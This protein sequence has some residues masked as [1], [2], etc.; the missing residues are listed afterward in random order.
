MSSNKKFIMSP[1]QA[2]MLTEANARCNIF[3]G[4][5][6]SGKS[7]GGFFLLPKRIKQ[8]KGVEGFCTLCG[9]TE[10]TIVRNTIMPLQEMYGHQY[11]S[12]LN[13]K[14]GECYIFGQRFLALPANDEK[15]ASK[16]QGLTIKYSFNDEAALYPENFHKQLQARLSAPGAMSDNFLN[17][18]SPYH[19][20]K[21]DFIDNPNIQ[22]YR[23]TFTLDD[24]KCFLSPEFIENLKREYSGVYKKRYI[25]GLWAIAEGSIYDMWSDE[26]NIIEELD[27]IPEYYFTSI[28]YATASVCT[29]ILFAVKGNQVRAVKQYYYDAVK[30]GRQKTDDE[31]VRD[32]ADFTNGFDVQYGYIDPSASSLKLELRTKSF[33]YFR[34][35]DND[36]L[37]GIKTVSKFIARGNYKVLSCCKELIREKSSYAWDKKAQKL[38]ID[39]PIKQDDH[40]SDAERYG[41]HSHLRRVA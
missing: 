35:A 5:V 3:D 40:S 17:P 1:K 38:G 9:K 29:F 33:G 26:I 28:D 20:F 16:A 13:Y 27:F 24:G 6:R 19:Y 25:D 23:L 21:Q 8:F 11:V 37:S 18:E 15:S 30:S 36:V 2:K 31:Y 4:A 12:D 34:S 39:A 14:T 7:K 32:Y 41:I 10:K 22:K